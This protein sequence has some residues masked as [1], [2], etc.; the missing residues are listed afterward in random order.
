MVAKTGKYGFLETI[1]WRKVD[2]EAVI[3]NLETSEYYSANDAGSRIWE[4]LANGAGS[5][6]IAH[7]LSE[8]YGLPLEEAERDTEDFLAELLKLEL[9]RAD[10]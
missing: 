5:R 2:S 3:L 10:A 8:E 1:A 6:K 7:A 4:L 9:I